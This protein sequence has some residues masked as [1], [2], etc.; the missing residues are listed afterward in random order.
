MA[1]ATKTVNK[2]TDYMCSELESYLA[3]FHFRH[4]LNK[5][6]FNL[7][8]M[9][10]GKTKRNEKNLVRYAQESHGKLREALQSEL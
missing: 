8:G 5:Y 3:S 2:I 7:N 1:M 9:L 4:A 6:V 10:N